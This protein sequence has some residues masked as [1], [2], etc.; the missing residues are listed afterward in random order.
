MGILRFNFGFLWNWERE[1]EEM[2]EKRRKNN[3]KKKEIKTRMNHPKE[4][5]RK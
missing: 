5:Y 3:L 4:Q 2:R 1:N